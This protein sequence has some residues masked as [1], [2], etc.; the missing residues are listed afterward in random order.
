MTVLAE[1]TPGR[2]MDEYNDMMKDH[3]GNGSGSDGGE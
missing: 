3:G 2:A 1:I